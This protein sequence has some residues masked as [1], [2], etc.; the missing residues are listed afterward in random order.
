MQK[1]IARVG[2]KFP[3]TSFLGQ[4][5]EAA[6]QA[7]DRGWTVSEFRKGQ[8]VMNVEEDNSDVF[9][10]LTGSVRVAL[11]TEGG[12]EVSVLTLRRGDCFGEFSA[13]DGAPRSAGIEALEPCLTARLSAAAFRDTLRATPDLSMTML[14]L[15]VGKLR[16]LTTKV[17]DFNALNA[18]Q[19]IRAELLRLARQGAEGRDEFVIER[20]PTQSEIAARVFSN[21]ETVA[22]EMGRL[23]KAG[24]LGRKGRGLHVPSLRLLEQALD[25]MPG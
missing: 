1:T 15:L 4:L 9:F 13:I 21:R 6:Y 17:S 8:M 19:R 12:R 24:L 20:P 18:D 16:V 3:E 10:L 23:K 14:E 22:R 5:S 2:Q 25:E 7:L 11:F